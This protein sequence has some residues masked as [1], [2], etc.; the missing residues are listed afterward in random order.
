MM[1]AKRMGPKAGRR[2]AAIMLALW[3]LFL[4]S[5]MVISWALDIGTRI[6]ISGNANRVVEATAMASSGAEIAIHPLVKAGSPSLR[7]SFGPGQSFEAR[8]TGEGGRLNLNWIVAP[9]DNPSRIELLRKYLEMKGVD[10][11]ERDHMIDCLLDW[12]DPENLVRL[13][14]AEDEP[15]YK[16]PNRL[17]MSVEEVKRVRGWEE[18]TARPD[19]DADFTLKSTGPIDLVWAPRDVLLALPGLSE[20]RITQF[21]T[22]RSG[23]DGIEG[24]EDD[25]VFTSPDE[26][27]IALGL[28]PA[29][30]KQ[31]QASGLVGLNDSVLRV[32][33][34]G[35]SGGVT[36][37][38]RMVIRKVGISVQLLTWKE[39]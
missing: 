13:N 4:L 10:L 33:S 26:I 1:A 31:L 14:G 17:L 19:W 22:L 8:I 25:P 24:T 21:L 3:A 39:F 20:M 38:V 2:G 11:N 9:P 30:F 12:V 18:F 29:Q 37:T 36:R 5:A 7:G 16:A 32:E 34:I 6:T 27:G 35:K 15:G 28:S 23:P